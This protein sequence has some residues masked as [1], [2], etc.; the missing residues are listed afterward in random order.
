[1]EVTVVAVAGQGRRFVLTDVLDAATQVFWRY[2][3]EG[4]SLTMLT[5]AMGIRPPSLYKAFG[6]KEGLFFTVIEHYNATHGRF[7]AEA[8]AEEPSSIG[9]TGRILRGAAR[10]YAR[11]EFPGGCLVISSAVT[12][13]PDNQ[14][15][16]DRLADMRN[17]NAAALAR[18]FERDIT[19][20]RL[21]STA[22]PAQLASFV[23]A[24]LQG[25]S[26]QG[27][28]G[29]DSTRLE[30]IA[31]LALNALPKPTE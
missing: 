6:S 23:G 30:S 17:T 28:D 1:L 31:A 4:T 24:T 19:S 15:I 2:G 25:M 22:D 21:P 9:I 20:G 18:V 7:V 27:R 13:T 8:F 26:Q 12:V 11:P 14:H 3:Y 29:A 5:D 16:A 10:H